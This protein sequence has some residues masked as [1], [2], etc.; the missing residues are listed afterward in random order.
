LDLIELVFNL[1]EPLEVGAEDSSPEGVQQLELAA[2]VREL[3]FTALG[4]VKQS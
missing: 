1:I 2:A 3:R 4:L